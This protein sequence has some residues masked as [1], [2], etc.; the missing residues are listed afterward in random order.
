MCIN[1]NIRYKCGHGEV[2]GSSICPFQLAQMISYPEVFSNPEKSDFI[3]P[4]ERNINEKDSQICQSCHVMA[5]TTFAKAVSPDNLAVPNSLSAAPLAGSIRHTVMVVIAIRNGFA[6]RT[7]SEKG[8]L[9][10]GNG[11]RL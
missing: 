2:L 3:C 5:M 9:R 4:K 8:K 1:Y 11:R 10:R 6:L 7:T